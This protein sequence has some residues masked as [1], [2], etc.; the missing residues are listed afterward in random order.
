VIEAASGQAALELWPQHSQEVALLLADVIMP[1]GVSGRQLAEQLHAQ[2]PGLKI[3]YIS[4]YPGDVAG[5][6]LELREDVNFLRKP[7]SS[8]KLGG[9]VRT[10]LDAAPES[11]S[12]NATANE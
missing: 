5:R 11:G 8:A 10:C 9:I 1:G 4:G 7:F 12:P 3:V 6:G 2:K